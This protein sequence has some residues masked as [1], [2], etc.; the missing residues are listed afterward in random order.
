MSLLVDGL[1]EEPDFVLC[2]VSMG[3]NTSRESRGPDH[4]STHAQSQTDG[5]ANPAS[6]TDRS[7][8]HNVYASRTPGRSR[9]DLS[10][11][12][13]GSSS[14]T[15]TTD[16]VPERRETKQERERRRI[17][18]E[19]AARIKEREKS[20]KEEHIDGGYLVTMGVY[21]GVEDFNKAV[22]R[23]LMVCA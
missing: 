9:H 4:P 7:Q 22:V 21:T 2:I 11:L 8:P 20:L 14:N 17:E 5:T 10:F 16:A 23:Q 15:A 19:K 12:G 3:S 6:T 13:L 18:K 1:D